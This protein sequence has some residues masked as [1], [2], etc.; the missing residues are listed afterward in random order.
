MNISG[1]LKNKKT[2]VTSVVSLI[3]CVAMYLVGDV[4]LID[5]LQIVIPLFGVIFLGS[6][7]TDSLQTKID[8]MNSKKK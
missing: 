3:S 8:E 4:S 2:V 5:L 1:C 7:L 6:E